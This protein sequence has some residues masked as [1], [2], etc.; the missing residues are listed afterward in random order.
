M[1][2]R[3][4][5]SI[6]IGQGRRETPLQATFKLHLLLSRERVS[7]VFRWEFCCLRWKGSTSTMRFQTSRTSSFSLQQSFFWKLSATSW[8]IWADR[9][10]YYR[11]QTTESVRYKFLSVHL[12]RILIVLCLR[13]EA[14][15]SAMT[16]YPLIHY[17]C[18]PYYYTSSLSS[19]PS[20]SPSFAFSKKLRTFPASLNYQPLL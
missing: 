9:F 5:V 17:L 4:H 15:A 20:S 2:L 6:C 19:P 12:R 13:F 16:T 10:D 11:R 14:L 1:R 7:W 3:H 18:S 8:G